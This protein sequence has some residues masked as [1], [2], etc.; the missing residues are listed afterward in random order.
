M[1]E[2]IKTTST[3]FSRESLIRLKEKL[4]EELMTA[5]EIAM[6]IGHSELT[7]KT[8][9]KNMISAICNSGLLIYEEKI[10]GHIKYG[11]LTNKGGENC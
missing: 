9:L 1:N 6:F 7:G 10:D 3:R 11:V 2:E 5:E 4:S 8:E